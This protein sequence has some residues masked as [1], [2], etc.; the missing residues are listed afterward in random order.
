MVNGP[1]IH[2]YPSV[3]GTKPHPGK[4][5][6]ANPNETY[7]ARLGVPDLSAHQPHGTMH[8]TPCVLNEL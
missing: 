1:F 3:F 8:S 6:A 7:A 2:H 5:V 4:A